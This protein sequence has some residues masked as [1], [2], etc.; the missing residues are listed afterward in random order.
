MLMRENAD[1][2]GV[3]AYAYLWRSTSAIERID[4]T[5]KSSG[6]FVSGSIATI[7]GIT[8]A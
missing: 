6:T 7:Y 4:I 2:S 1:S 3:G 8:A 5:A